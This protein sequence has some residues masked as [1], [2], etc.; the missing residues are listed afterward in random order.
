MVTSGSVNS[1]KESVLQGL[2]QYATETSGLESI[3]KGK[4]Y[5]SLSSQMAEVSSEFKTAIETNMTNFA[6]ACDKYDEYINTKKMIEANKNDIANWEKQKA[7]GDYNVDKCQANI[8]KANTNI[9]ELEQNLQDIE[10][11][12][13][14]AL[15]TAKGAVLKASPQNISGSIAGYLGKNFIVSQ[16]SGYVFPLAKGVNAP[17]TSHVGYRSKASTNGVGSTNHQGTDIGIPTGTKLYSLSNGVVTGAGR[18]GGYGNRVEVK[19]DDGTT[20][21]YG[22]LSKVNC[23]EGDRVS[24]GDLLG[25]SGSTGN[26]TGPHLHLE[27]HDS[28]GNLLDSENVFKDC[29]PS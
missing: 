7:S 18:Y 20:V 12:I 13:K 21:L 4:S 1:S 23:K 2:N 17:I 19:L 22:H 29:W 25:L 14:S 10:K 8:N 9:A 6:I 27:M 11:A 24:G 5:E 15:S 28:K 3:W 26:S 16:K